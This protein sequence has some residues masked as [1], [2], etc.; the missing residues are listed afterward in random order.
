MNPSDT[1]PPGQLALGADLGAPDHGPGCLKTTGR[2]HRFPGEPRYI[3]VPG[4]PRQKYLADS[5]WRRVA[6]EGER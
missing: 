3:C 2:S 5:T 4:C 1:R 6:A